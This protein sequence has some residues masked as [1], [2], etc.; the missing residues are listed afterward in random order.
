MTAVLALFALVGCTAQG[1]QGNTGARP[2]ASRAKK[3]D[4]AG[5]NYT[6]RLPIAAYSYTDAE[7][8][9]IDAAENVLADKC[10]ARYSLTYRPPKPTPAVP[11]ADRRYGLSEE[12]S[13]ALFGYRPDS[14]YRAAS[15]P[16]KLGKHERIVL[17]GN[18]EGAGKSRSLEYRGKKVPDH[19]CLGQAKDDFGKAYAYPEG[20]G[21]ASRI[22]SQSYRQS[23]LL[24]EVQAVF[25]AWSAC[26][27]K[28][29]YIYGSPSDPFSAE[30]FRE[31][32]V[33]A[34]EK[35]TAQADVACKRSTGLLE[36][37]FTAESE[38]QKTMIA[39]H[40]TSLEKLRDLHAKKVA[41][42]RK[43]LAEG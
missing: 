17:Y 33:T 26:M 23:M 14:S 19:G 39:E 30:K 16:M 40:S 21:K 1:P 28:S 22:S 32:P 11:G 2:E 25:N 9:S 41:A 3:S 7:Y 13:A 12:R 43:V 35:E 6:Y 42:A 24:P 29:G 10:M 5:G 36:V 37:W 8:A 4:A 27:K 38:V 18:R 31:G 20:A 34:Q 15:Q